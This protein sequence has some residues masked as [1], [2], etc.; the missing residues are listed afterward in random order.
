[1]APSILKPFPRTDREVLK[2]HANR[3]TISTSDVMLVARRNEDLANVLEEFINKEKAERERQSAIAK[4][5][6]KPVTGK[7]KA[8]K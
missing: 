6:G 4:G 5:K 8:K 7:G 1:M 3:T 2:S